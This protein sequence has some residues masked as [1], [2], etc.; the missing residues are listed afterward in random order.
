VRRKAKQARYALEA[1][2]VVAGKREAIRGEI[3]ASIQGTLGDH[4]D[5]VV[6]RHW[7]LDAVEAIDE[8]RVGFIAGLLS[9]LLG[10][11]QRALRKQARRECRDACRS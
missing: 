9:G 10:S 6:A 4:Q 7:L 8:A 5:R 2:G 3:A 1:I 11:E